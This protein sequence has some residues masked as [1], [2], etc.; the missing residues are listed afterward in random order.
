MIPA[1]SSEIWQIKIDAPCN[2]ERFYMHGICAS[3]IK[4]SLRVNEVD[5]FTQSGYTEHSRA[6][7]AGRVS[8]TGTL[9]LRNICCFRLFRTDHI[10]FRK[11]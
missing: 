9:V 11:R 3:N 5:G 2:T 1:V 7:N 4:L 6:G 8:C 10:R